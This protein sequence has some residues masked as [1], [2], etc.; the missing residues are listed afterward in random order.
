M[1]RTLT[2]GA[3]AA[4]AVAWV[5]FR[6]G[7]RRR[8]LARLPEISDDEFLLRF[9]KRFLAPP[10]GVLQARRKVARVLGVPERKLAPEHTFK[11]LARQLELLGDLGIA[12]DELEELVNDAAWKAAP[13]GSPRPA[14]AV[15]ACHTVGDLVTGLIQAQVAEPPADPAR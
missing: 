8:A 11:D 5:T 12:W 1:S 15:G 4:I 14:E 13:P 6:W 3:L 10:D 7:Y 9:G 2:W